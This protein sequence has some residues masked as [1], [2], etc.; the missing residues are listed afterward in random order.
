MQASADTLLQS[1][2]RDQL[3]EQQIGYAN[4]SIMQFKSSA[5]ELQ[6]KLD[7]K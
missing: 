7:L 5:Y 2:E 3:Y 4:S 6:A 1:V